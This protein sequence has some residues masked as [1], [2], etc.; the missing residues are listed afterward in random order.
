MSEE[1]KVEVGIGPAKLSASGS[2]VAKVGRALSDLLSPFSEGFGLVGDHIRMYRERSVRNVLERAA[3]IAAERN[4]A[5]EPVNPKNLIPLLENASLEAPEDNGL[6][7]V[8]ARLLLSGDSE[9]DAELAVFS[10]T[11]K[12]IGKREAE[13]LKEVVISDNQFPDN[14]FDDLDRHY[15]DLRIQ[16][17]IDSLVPIDDNN[18]FSSKAKELFDGAP[19]ITFGRPMYIGEIG[20]EKKPSRTYFSSIFLQS[21][22][23]IRILEREG[24]AS[25]VNQKFSA[26]ATVFS[27]VY[28]RASSLGVSLIA[29][30]YPK[31]TS[32]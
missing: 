20:R 25:I 3:E 27:F 29:R 5:V 30:C 23:S 9:F 28:F 1:E 4:E 26:G 22:K 2:S 14:S 31:E 7:D 17:V 10:D 12:R 24:L 15:D 18:K 8:W 16:R 11:L 21:D 6:L 13:I 32:T 19:P